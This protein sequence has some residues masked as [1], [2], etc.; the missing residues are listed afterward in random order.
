MGILQ[1][2]MIGFNDTKD[3]SLIYYSLKRDI[4]YG[5]GYMVLLKKTNNSWKIMDKIRIWI[6]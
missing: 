4:R 3:T 6:S 1:F 2:S 5:A